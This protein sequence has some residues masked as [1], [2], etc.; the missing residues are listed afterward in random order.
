MVESVF[1]LFGE[2]TNPPVWP[3]SPHPLPRVEPV[4][5][6]SRDL[7]STL[8]MA[9]FLLSQAFPV[10][11][12]S[13][14]SRQ[15]S[16]TLRTC[17]DAS[18]ASLSF[19]SCLSHPTHPP[20]VSFASLTPPLPAPRWSMV[21]TKVGDCCFKGWNVYHWHCPWQQVFLGLLF[22]SLN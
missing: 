5:P 8:W 18:K 16:P 20:Q 17:Q 6:R 9:D 14:L 21:P 4:L 7:I 10:L 15:G 3:I 1:F 22:N 13:C 11:Q 2:R 19:A 12:P